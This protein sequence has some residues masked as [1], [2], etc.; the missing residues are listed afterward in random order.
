MTVD[1]TGPATSSPYATGGG[2]TRLEHRYGATLLTALLTGDPITE[3]GDDAAPHRIRYQDPTS[4]IDD[5]V[6][7]TAEG[8]RVSIGVRRAPAL[9]S[10]DEHSVPLLRSYLRVIIENRTEVEA[11]IWRLALVVASAN[12]AA[13]QLKQLAVVAHGCT[14]AADFRTDV[15]RPG[16]VDEPVRTRLRHLDALVRTA[17]HSLNGTTISTDELTWRLLAV[18][19]IEQCLKP[20]DD[21]GGVVPSR[22]S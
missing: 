4:P 21:Q 5:F 13:S 6:V 19:Q 1:R 15:A 12:P 8:R 17:A 14:S 22:S 7:S 20:V 9:T 2:G 11:G 16:R 3:L 10:S 18:L